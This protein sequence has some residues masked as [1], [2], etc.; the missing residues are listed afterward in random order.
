MKEKCRWLKE[1]GWKRTIEIKL[2]GKLAIFKTQTVKLHNTG[3]GSNIIF[4]SYDSHLKGGVEFPET[5]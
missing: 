3:R 5:G 4:F 2:N 1:I